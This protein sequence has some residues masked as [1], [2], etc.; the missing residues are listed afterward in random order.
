MPELPEVENVARGLRP[1]VGKKLKNLEIVDARVWFE[2]DLE[3][4]AFLGKRLS[5]VSRRGKYLI[6]RYGRGLSMLVHLRMTGKVLDAKSS[7]IPISLLEDP[8]GPKRFQVRTR[9]D[10]ESRPMVFFDPRRFGTITA[11]SDEELFFERKGIA[12][13]PIHDEARAKEAF[14]G[15]I[16]KITR[17]IKPSL[18]D[19]TVIAG[20]GNIYADEV[21][22]QV[23]IH[24]E[25]P[26][27]RVKQPE[28]IWNSVREILLRS[29][30]SG[31]SSIIDYVNAEGERGTFS[32]QLLVYGRDGELCSKCGNEIKR[33]TLGGRSTHFCAKCQPRRRG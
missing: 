3:P 15:R 7:L 10:F 8:N 21:L 24:P 19:Q 18:L 27:F 23:G 22:F 33:I 13:D 5:E 28:L 2:G 4:D 31:G 6:L 9:L 1:L 14:L 29:I 26:A 30:E 11:V 20:V 12:P 32:S 17:A 25:L 16:K